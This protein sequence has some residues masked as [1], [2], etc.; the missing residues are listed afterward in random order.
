MTEMKMHNTQALAARVS[1]LID[2]MGSRC[3]HLDRLSVEQ[4]Q[5]V[6]DGDVELVLDVLQRREPVL[7]ALAVA[8]EQ[9]G[10]M[11]EDG[12]C[13]S[14]MGPALFADARERLREL[15]RVADG[16]RERDAEHH[17]LMKQQRDG[18]AAR[19]SSMGQQKS[20]MSAYSGNKGTPNPTL[21]D[22]RG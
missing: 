7:R 13:I 22:R 10:A 21:Q 4:G 2:E 15:E 19:L 11:L 5:A 12:A 8:G 3:A 9:L 14:A 6:R 1:T 20:A 18:L 16:I 17:Q